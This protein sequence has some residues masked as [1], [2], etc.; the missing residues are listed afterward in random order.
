MSAFEKYNPRERICE[1]INDSDGFDG[2]SVL[3]FMKEVRELIELKKTKSEYPLLNFYCNWCVHPELSDSNTIYNI[4]EEISEIFLSEK[5]AGPSFVA[6]VN[7]LLSMEELRRQMLVLLGSENIPDFWFSIPDNWQGFRQRLLANIV[8]KP[9]QFPPGTAEYAKKLKK[10]L[11]VP[12]R[13]RKA[14]QV[15]CRIK[16]KASGLMA[17]RLHLDDRV[18]GKKKGDVYWVVETIPQRYIMSRLLFRDR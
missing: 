12:E 1:R 6:Q 4:L 14:A 7:H 16:K 5:E 8:Q 2:D 15:Y 9:I 3:A 17:T 11:K 10:G 13:Y 18:K